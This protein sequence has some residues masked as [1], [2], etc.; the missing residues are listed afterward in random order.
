MK[1]TAIK[2]MLS[3]KDKNLSEDFDRVF[4]NE[5]SIHAYQF[6]R[7]E[8]QLAIVAS[9]TKAEFQEFFE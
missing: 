3:E 5:L 8:R 2:T 4:G 7:Q 6:D 9:L 1:T